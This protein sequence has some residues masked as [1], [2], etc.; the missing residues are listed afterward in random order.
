MPPFS[1]VDRRGG[2]FV[3]V[4]VVLLLCPSPVEGDDV[5]LCHRDIPK[6]SAPVSL[7][8]L[9]YCY[10]FFDR[11]S[12]GHRWSLYSSARPEVIRAQELHAQASKDLKDLLAS[13][14]VGQDHLVAP[15]LTA[16]QVKMLHPNDPMTLHFVGENGVGKT[17]LASLIS[18]A[19]SFRCHE[20][21]QD[22]R[23]GVCKVGETM[24]S[25]SCASYK[26][27][28]MTES[29]IF[30]DIRKKIAKHQANYPNGIV[31]L[32]EVTELPVGVVQSLRP[33]FRG[34]NFGGEDRTLGKILLILTS[35]LGVEG[36]TRNKSVT[37]IDQMVRTEL[38]HLY[39]TFSLTH[40]RNFVFLPMSYAELRS[41]VR[42]RVAALPCVFP[43]LSRLRTI[44]SSQTV[45]LLLQQELERT[46]VGENGR[47]ADDLVKNLEAKLWDFMVERQNDIEGT[48]E[49]YI[50]AGSKKIALRV[51]SHAS[52]AEDL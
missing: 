22:E 52:D 47:V 25:I 49:F 20:G 1:R 14:F 8:S 29:Q 28:G 7:S 5:P 3:L 44:I 40:T 10:G 34:N 19:L 30:Q 26:G 46:V 36:R 24:F 2:V 33:L 13:E 21:E 50:D 38:M 43:H 48:V 35:D 27:S 31:L 4:C 16:V 32:D 39:G 9:W 41:L 23:S 18:R 17:F 45:E 42:R 51:A 37:E 15:I 11:F 12:S 6:C